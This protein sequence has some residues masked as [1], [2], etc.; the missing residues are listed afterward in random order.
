MRS[1]CLLPQKKS[2]TI[3]ESNTDEQ[4]RRHKSHSSVDSKIP[5]AT[6]IEQQPLVVMCSSLSGT[7]SNLERV[8][9]VE[10]PRPATCF[11]ACL[12]GR[13]VKRA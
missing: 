7:F 13:S 2:L 11:I 4:Q 6:A 5:E 9:F 8:P 1:Q 3:A 12:L 10:V